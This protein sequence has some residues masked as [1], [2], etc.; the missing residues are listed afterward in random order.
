MSVKKKLTG[1]EVM[2]LKAALAEYEHLLN[3]YPEIF[4]DETEEQLKIAL[5][6]MYEDMDI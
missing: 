4:T 2:H 6:I 1:P 5:E 3:D